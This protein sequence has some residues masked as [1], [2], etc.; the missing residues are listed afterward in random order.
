MSVSLIPLEELKISQYN[1][2]LKVDPKR[3][4]DLMESI[5]RHGLLNPL[6]VR[7]EGDKYGIV[8]GRLRFEAINL[9]KR[10]HPEDFKR[11]FGNGIKVTIMELSPPEA[12]TLS[13]TENKEQNTIT[14]E[15]IARATNRLLKYGLSIE[16]I[17]SQT[18]IDVETISRLQKLYALAKA[19]KIVTGPGR[20]KREEKQRIS[21]MTI[22]LAHDTADLLSKRGF[23]ST[24]DKEN[25][26]EEFI[27]A[28]KGLS[29]REVILLSR[30]VKSGQ[31]LHEAVKEIKSEERVSMLI[32]IPKK[33]ADK[34]RKIARKRRITIDETIT[35]LLELALKETKL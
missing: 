18:G 27:D 8:C 32:N 15:E 20:P 3:I 21:K 4:R 24:E 13:I 22:I 12:I 10:N 28:A 23:L 9:M 1:V 16:E 5:R 2:R 11:L 25:F 35:Y 30:K 31:P 26:I 7:K 6:I 29:T 19:A 14:E 34:V 33:I 17:A